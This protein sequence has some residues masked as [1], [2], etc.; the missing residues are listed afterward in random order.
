MSSAN[1][2]ALAKK[3]AKAAIRAIIGEDAKIHIVIWSNEYPDDAKADGL[4]RDLVTRASELFSIPPSNIF[5]PKKHIEFT[6]RQT[7]VSIAYYH[8]PTYTQAKL[9]NVMEV[10]STAHISHFVSCIKDKISKYQHGIP[11]EELEKEIL[12]KKHKLYGNP[13]NK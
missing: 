13:T 6:A 5:N 11:Y 10:R 2:L 12:D 1:K 8:I 4:F 3:T 9:F 7:V